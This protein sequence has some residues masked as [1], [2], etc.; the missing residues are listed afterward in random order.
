MQLL[1]LVSECFIALALM[2]FTDH[3]VTAAT[4]L[5]LSPV[6]GGWLSFLRAR[7][8][9]LLL[10]TVFLATCIFR[11][12]DA[13][14]RSGEFARETLG[15]H[16]AHHYQSHTL[17]A[18]GIYVSYE[19]GSWHVFD[20]DLLVSSYGVFRFLWFPDNTITSLDNHGPHRSNIAICL[21]ALVFPI[22][23]GTRETMGKGYISRKKDLKGLADL[24]DRSHPGPSNR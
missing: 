8:Q 3:L 22:S 18:H 23:A 16:A 19:T 12:G 24:T 5:R 2:S 6:R 9:T 1:W 11:V 21:T 15:S 14:L 10:I 13:L 20:G 4:K 7:S 17:D